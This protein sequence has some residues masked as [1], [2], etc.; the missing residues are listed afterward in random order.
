[1]KHLLVDYI[2]KLIEIAIKWIIIIDRVSFWWLFLV[3]VLY[4]TTTTSIEL[5][6]KR[7]EHEEEEKSSTALNEL[8]QQEMRNKRPSSRL[9]S[10]CIIRY[11]QVS[12]LFIYLSIFNSVFNKNIF[13]IIN[14]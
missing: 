10:F 7:I 5:G 4:F 1:M 6:D 3:S 11:S 8:E 12:F 9:Q 2:I 13:L 14:N